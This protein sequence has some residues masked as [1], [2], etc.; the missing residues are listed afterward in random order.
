MQELHISHFGLTHIRTYTVYML[1][2]NY[3]ILKVHLNNA[4]HGSM[5]MQCCQWSNLVYMYIAQ[6]VNL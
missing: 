5:D 2:Y 3:V 1:D 4:M 6:N